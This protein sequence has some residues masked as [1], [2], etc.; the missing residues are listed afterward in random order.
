VLERTLR[1]VDPDGAL[2]AAPGS[3]EEEVALDDLDSSDDDV[4]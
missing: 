2:L 1:L 3:D 4:A